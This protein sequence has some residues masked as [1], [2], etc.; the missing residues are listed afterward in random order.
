MNVSDVD[1][2]VTG[3]GSVRPTI[4]E[5]L[6]ALS[7]TLE[8]AETTTAGRVI[9]LLKTATIT[10]MKPA[11]YGASRYTGSERYGP[12]EKCSNGDSWRSSSSY[13]RGSYSGRSDRYSSGGGQSRKDRSG[14]YDRPSRA[15]AAG[16]SYVNG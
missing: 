7:V 14:P 5:E 13:Y 12:S 16:S 10:G 6:E 11:G 3:L 8:E 4:E 2:P 1:S 9:D 15:A